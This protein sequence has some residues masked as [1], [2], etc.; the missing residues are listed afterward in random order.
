MGYGLSR[1]RLRAFGL[2]PR[3]GSHL[4][5]L[6]LGVALLELIDHVFHVRESGA[7][8]DPREKVAAACGNSLTVGDHIELAELTRRAH[9]IDA[10]ALP[11]E[12]RE[13]RDLGFGALSRGAVNDLDLRVV[14]DLPRVCRTT[15]LATICAGIVARPEPDT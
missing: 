3:N 2:W 13:T 12:G 1:A 10:Q 5:R 4:E 9:W 8:E 7:E 11:D 6:L 14:H 15:E